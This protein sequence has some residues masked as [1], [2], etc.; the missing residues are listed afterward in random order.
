M[1]RFCAADPL[2]SVC[3]HA[4]SACNQAS[5]IA[6][7]AHSPTGQGLGSGHPA[8][9]TSHTSHAISCV[10]TGS[11][12]HVWACCADVRLHCP[13]VAFRARASGV[14]V[15]CRVR[16]NRPHALEAVQGPL[17]GALL[18]ALKFGDHEASA[19][20][21][22]YQILYYQAICAICSLLLWHP[23]VTRP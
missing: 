14:A 4:I 23:L 8:L 11:A 21:H 15:H 13:K 6:D 20:M 9:T 1:M 22:I 12:M 2:H 10:I 18:G 17:I 3:V 19:P 7:H 16:K 5:N